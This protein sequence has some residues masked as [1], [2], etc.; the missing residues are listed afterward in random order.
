MR[1]NKNKLKSMSISD[2]KTI[3]DYSLYQIEHRGWEINKWSYIGRIVIEELEKRIDECFITNPKNKY[4][5]KT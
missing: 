1:Y 5:A 3:R 2:L 4:Y